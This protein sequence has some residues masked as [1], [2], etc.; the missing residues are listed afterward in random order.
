MPETATSAPL[1]LWSAPRS[2][3]TA[4]FRMMAE[5]DEF[6]LVHE[7]FSE[8]AAGRP[9][10]VGEQK[11]ANAAEL[12]EFLWQQERPVFF[13]DTTE[14]RHVDL[15]DDHPGLAKMTHT[16]LI[17]D[18]RRVID[19]HYAMNADVT[20]DE[21]GFEYLYEIFLAAQA[22][23]GTTPIV[24]DADELLLDPPA[25][26]AA[27]CDRLGL[28]ERPDALT[29]TPGGRNEWGA[30]SKWHQDAAA[31]AAFKPSE[32]T[33]DVT[34]ENN[35]TLAGYLAYQQPFYDRLRAFRLIPTRES[36]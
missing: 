2:M 32:R 8:L 12:I 24:V 29:W 35:E 23:S 25:M 31:S 6:T 7:P 34:T 13:K 18:P 15:F 4:F 5:R 36:Q 30:T 26:V 19:S 22:Q 3:S 1:A 28:A 33:Y 14:Y 20:R 21:I 9:A 27:Y 11:L 16:F 10:T 17:R